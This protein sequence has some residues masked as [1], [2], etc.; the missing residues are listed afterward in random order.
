MQIQFVVMCHM[1]RNCSGDEVRALV[2]R[3]QTCR[4]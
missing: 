3:K 1:Y 4:W 2:E